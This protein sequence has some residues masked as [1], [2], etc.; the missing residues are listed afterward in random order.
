MVTKRDLLVASTRYHRAHLL[1]HYPRPPCVPTFVK[2]RTLLHYK[3]FLN[4]YS[5][6]MYV[7][8]RAPRVMASGPNPCGATKKI[9]RTVKLRLRILCFFY[10]DIRLDKWLEPLIKTLLYSVVRKDHVNIRNGH[11]IFRPSEV[12]PAII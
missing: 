1:K 7:Y 6:S 11:K 5:L 2:S 9:I 8:N 12:F 3:H 4:R 10:V